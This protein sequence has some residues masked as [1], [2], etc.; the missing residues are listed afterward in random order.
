MNKLYYTALGDSLTNSIAADLFDGFAYQ[1]CRYFKK[2]CDDVCFSNLGRS[3]L[4]SCGLLTM[5]KHCCSVRCR[6][7]DSD[8]ITITIGGNDLLCCAYN[9]YYCIDK[10]CAEKAVKKFRCNWVGI[11]ETIRRDLCSEADIY[12]MTMY[13]PYCPGDC[14]YE[15][16]E[17]FIQQL[18]SIIADPILTYSYNY[19]IVDI[20]S[21]FKYNQKKCLTFFDRLIRNPHPTCTGNCQIADCFIKSIDLDDDY[22]AN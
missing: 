19:N 17:Y 9:N 16:A 12:V 21:C 10:R 11:M 13:N 1:I 7:K 4:K 15:V 20:Y 6:V 22:Y 8:I 14:N 3:G 18:N 2:N 5:L